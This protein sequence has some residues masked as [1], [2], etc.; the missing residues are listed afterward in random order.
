M[1]YTSTTAKKGKLEQ[2]QD[3]VPI[4]GSTG[5]RM[6]YNFCLL[7]P[8]SYYYRRAGEYLIT[9]LAGRGYLTLCTVRL[10]NLLTLIDGDF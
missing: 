9:A 3:S 5:H 10:L 2:G 8:R 6:G 4:V 1:D 7:R